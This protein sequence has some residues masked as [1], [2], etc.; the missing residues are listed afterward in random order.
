M[1]KVRSLSDPQYVIDQYKEPTNLNSRLRLHQLFS[2]NKYGW[3]RWL[4][5]QFNIPPRPRILEL[6]CGAGDLW[7]SNLDRVPADWDIVLSDFSAGMVKEAQK[8][9]PTANEYFNI[10][11]LMQHQ[12]P[13]I[14]TVLILLS[15]TICFIMCP[16]E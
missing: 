1:L 6:G 8:N 14:T 2:T 7:L 5:D 3:Y 16:I 4:F 9:L 15:R 11:F 13:T 10:K 12:Y